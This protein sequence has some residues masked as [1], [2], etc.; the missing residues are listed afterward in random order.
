MRAMFSLNKVNIIHAFRI[1]QRKFPVFSITILLSTL[2]IRWMSS[3]YEGKTFLDFNKFS[4]LMAPKD[5][6]TAPQMQFIKIHSWLYRG[7]RKNFLTKCLPF[8]SDAR[9][10]LNWRLI[11]LEWFKA[12]K[13]FELG[14]E[15]EFCKCLKPSLKMIVPGWP[16]PAW[17]SRDSRAVDDCLIY[18]SCESVTWTNNIGSVWIC[19][20]TCFIVCK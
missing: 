9:T 10:S 12:N 16:H 13:R 7:T 8:F 11:S 14:I 1:C 6:I 20:F 5:Q 18:L 3:K 15:L 17:L 19:Y 4:E 2:G